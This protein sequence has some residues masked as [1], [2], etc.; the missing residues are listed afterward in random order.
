MKNFSKPALLAA[1]L[2]P[3]AALAQLNVGDMAGTSEGAILAALAA[4]GYEVLEIEIE[5]GEFEI[6]VSLDGN[7]FEIEVDMHSGIVTEI[8]AEDDDGE[9]D[10][11]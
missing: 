2:I 6:E 8:E 9:D 4:Q 7:F 1:L 11:D 5:D 10:D 3:G